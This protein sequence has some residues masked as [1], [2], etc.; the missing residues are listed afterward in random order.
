MSAPQLSPEERAQLLQTFL[1]E[2]GENLA[3]MEEALVTLERRPGDLELVH[4]LFRLAHSLKGDARMT[5]FPAIADFAHGVEDALARL[6]DR[7]VPVTAELVTRLLQAVDV[8]RGMTHA[9]AAG[10]APTRAEDAHAL[11]ALGQALA[12]AHQ[13][14]APA[15]EAAQAPAAEPAGPR[16]GAHTLRVD[17]A[18]LDRMLDL[19][20]EITIA[21]G[22]VQQLLEA[23]P[24]AAG[25]PALEAFLEAVRLQLALQEE[26]MDAR[27]VPVAPFF[28]QYARTVRDLAASAGKQATLA[29]EGDD[30]EVDTRVLEALRDPVT[31]MV[32]NAVDHG[33][34]S[35]EL[36]AALGK[37][38]EGRITLRAAQEGG[39]IVVQVK[40]DGAGID[41]RRVAAR[42][43]ATGLAAAPEQLSDEALLELV[44]APG[45]TT[46]DAVTQLSGRGVGMDVVRRNI[47]ALRGTVSLASLP[48]Q[49]TTIT[50]RL[51]LTLAIIDG[52][53][54]G[55]GAETY[56]LPLEAVRECLALPASARDDGAGGG[57]LD[58][59]GEPLPYIRVRALFGGDGEAPARAH[60]VVVGHGGRRAGL[61]VDTLHGE[62]Q[63]VI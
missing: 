56:V 15:T 11:A 10:R 5:G 4:E 30:V 46:A 51:P 26:V 38:A 36:R 62:R 6:R 45:F 58:L 3:R 37:P 42:A 39:Q 29:V 54:V 13:G 7:E 25:G 33:L 24:A 40:D 12:A 44:F 19:T 8:L 22:R 28:R 41:R 2:A 47:E 17:V 50:I 55:V 53:G 61:V 31:H 23:L 49:G 60:V 27:L 59:R 21:Q 63:A 9:A 20:G 16:G 1:A 34:E 35:P 48:D 43:R 14:T 32:R 52:F 18:K 57:L